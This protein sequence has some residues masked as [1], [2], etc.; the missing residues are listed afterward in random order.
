MGGS[1]RRR[2]VAIG[3]VAAIALALGAA[4]V[5]AAAGGDGGESTAAAAS[6]DDGGELLAQTSITLDEAIAAAS[7]AASGAIGEIDLEHY[8]GVLVFNVD[9]GDQDVKVD[10]A[11]GEV[12][13]MAED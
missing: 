4:G 6:I 7:S 13:G 9:V 5:A 2:N 12:I 1:K 8:H 10:A 3:G 11:T